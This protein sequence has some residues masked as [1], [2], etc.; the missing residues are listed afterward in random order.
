MASARDRTVTVDGLTLVVP[1]GVCNPAPAFGLSFAPLFR[2]ALDDLTACETLL[3]VGTGCGVWALLAARA[4]AVVTAT[5]LEEVSFDALRQSAERN[6]LVVPRNLHGSL[7][8]PVRGE[9]FDR[10]VFNPPF[11]LGAPTTAQ[12]RAYLGGADGEVVRGYLRAVREHL[13]PAGRAFVILPRIE[14]RAYQP[15]LALHVPEIRAE[16]SLPLLGRV[17]L[18]ELLSH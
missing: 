15:D 10:V 1:A 18:I 11:H 8:A 9:R 4:G 6:G 12:E 5:D 14:Q 13:S 17:E 7:F 16:M 2:A 3:D